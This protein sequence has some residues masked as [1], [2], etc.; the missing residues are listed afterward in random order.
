MSI[1]PL[2]AVSALDGR[3]AEQL[4]G[5][6]AVVSEGALIKYR[7]IVEAAW[8][9]ELGQA[10]LIDLS[11]Q[12]SLFLED[13]VKNG[14]GDQAPAEVKALERTT[15]HDVKAVEY[16]IKNRLQSLGATDRVLSHIHFACTSE[17]INNLAYAMMVRDLRDQVVMPAFD[18]IIGAIN[19]VAQ[20]LKATPML[21]RTHGQSATPSTMGKEFAVFAFRLQRQRRHLHT[22]EILGKFNGAVGNFNAHLAA[23]PDIDWPKLSKRFV[24]KRLGFTWNPLTTQ[25]ESHDSFVEFMTVIRQFNTI[26]LDF[27]RDMWG[28]ISLGYFAQKVIAGEVGSS[29]MPHKVNPIYFENAE[30]NIGVS[31]SL[32]NHFS[33][34][35]PVSR[36]Q[37]DLSDSTVLRVTGTA[38]GHGVLAWR[39][40]MKGMERVAANP[41][42]MRED[43]SEAWEVLAEP[44]QS[45]MRRY[46]VADAYEL[47]KKAT[48]GEAVV[49]KAMIHAA[50]DHCQQIPTVEKTRMKSWTPETY[51]GLAST[52]VE[53]FSPMNAG[54]K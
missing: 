33:E 34:K 31:N 5:L 52:L 7:I 40:L 13:L 51:T 17:D 53:Q 36:W 18:Q 8:L 21:S 4:S 38:V 22:Q 47:L 54:S 6:G 10:G 9:L 24:E 3:Y 14:G 48:R 16:W 32:L 41:V 29:T 20:D 45:V 19:Q 50:I 12:V 25:I 26:L 37:R 28:Y 15:N 30:G 23:C 42:R 44:V 49:T 43:L 46:G 27:S 2:F 11:P 35:L 39:S 1:N